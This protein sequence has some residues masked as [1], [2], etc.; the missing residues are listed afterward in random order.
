MRGLLHMRMLGALIACGA[1][2]A[3]AAPASAQGSYSPYA[4]SPAAALARY[5]RTL[6]S[7]P[8]DF[9]SLIGA[10]KS[11]LALGDN[12]AAAGFFARAD[13]VNP[14][15]PMPQAGMGAVSVANGEPQ[16]ALPYFT[17]AQ[18][19]G[20]PVAVFGADRGLA[21]DLLGQQANAQADYRA[22]LGGPDSDE[23][24]RRLALSLAIGGNKAE[25]LAMLAPLMAKGDAAAARARAFV[26]ALTGDSNGAMVAIDA[27]MPGSWAR[28]QPF[29]SRLPT[30]LPAQKAAA[31]NLGIFP[32]AGDTAYAY[33]APVQNYGMPRATTTQVASDRLAGVD[34]LLKVAPQQAAPVQ[35]AYSAPVRIPAQPPKSASGSAPG[36]IWLQLASGA[37][38]SALPSQFKRIKNKNSDLMDGIKGYIAKSPDR[39]RLVIGPFRG[40]SD[41]Q[42]FAEDLESVG[43]NAFRWTNSQADQIV[44]L[45]T[46]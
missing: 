36:K 33:S 41:A 3:A 40:T 11:A 25:A 43:V 39:T 7:D 35:V 21:Y 14:R 31:V 5:V 4:E 12:Q 38:G 29:L 18:Q 16:G 45:A 34:D 46:E 19:L 1:A 23:A 30:L 2:V 32:D 28:V 20:A 37:N 15:S 10:G 9:S 27:A 6:A 13:E 26:C 22:A 24:R 42:I 44:P 8:K 17:R